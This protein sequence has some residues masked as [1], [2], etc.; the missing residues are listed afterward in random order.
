MDCREPETSTAVMGMLREGNPDMAAVAYA[1]YVLD[2]RD[3]FELCNG[4]LSA[5]RG[6][7][8]GMEGKAVA[9]D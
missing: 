7:Y 2:V 5:L 1:R 8:A 9:D 6:W 3:A 4:K